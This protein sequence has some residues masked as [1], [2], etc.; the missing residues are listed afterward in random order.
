MLASKNIGKIEY[1]KVRIGVRLAFLLVKVRN[2][3]GFPTQS[4]QGMHIYHRREQERQRFRRG[5]MTFEFLL[6]TLIFKTAT[7]PLRH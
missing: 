4:S 2:G 1:F 3:G 5:F 7:A 6:F